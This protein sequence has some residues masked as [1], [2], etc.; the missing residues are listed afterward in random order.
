MKQILEKLKQYPEIKALFIFIFCAIVI[1]F[2]TNNF[3][4]IFAP[5]IIA[6]IIAKLLYPLTSW[7]KK[8]LKT[9]NIINTIICMILFS[10]LSALLLWLVGNYFV[11]GVEYIVALLSNQETID[12][13]ISFVQDIGVKLTNLATFLHIEVDVNELSML[14]TD[15]ATTALGSISN[16]S[17]SFAMQ[18]PSFIL[19]F[20]IGCVSAFYMLYDYDKISRTIRKQLS[21]KTKAVVDIFNRQVMVSLVKMIFSYAILSV[22][23]FVEL[24]VGF[25]ILGIEDAGFIAL[26]IAILDV[27]PILGS[28]A[29][30]APW[31]IISL[32]FG[33]VFV[34]VGMFVLW[35]IIV[36]VR[37]VLEPKIVGSQIG[38]YPLITLITL[39]LGVKLMGG[40]GLIVAPLYV[41]TCKKLNEAGVI[42]L[43]KSS[44]KE[45]QQ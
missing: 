21:E 6:Y 1:V 17:I 26:L 8:K 35:G 23:C 25:F 12:S 19:S 28:G 43:Y 24:I 29:V 18:V 9:P 7:M 40:V 22:I 30:L 13:M 45:H 16:W 4:G 11:S 33:D 27:L 14:V 2:I 20:I 39:F 42:T 15:F 44:N 10:L 37:Q 36:V 34:G 5:F 41:L 3:F 31:G 38:L 32:L